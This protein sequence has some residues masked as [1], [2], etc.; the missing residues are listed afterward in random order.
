MFPFVFM[1]RTMHA[2]NLLLKIKIMRK[3]FTNLQHHGTLHGKSL[4]FEVVG[5]Q[6][7]T[8]VGV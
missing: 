6:I 4:H 8:D 5:Q 2:K 7:I 3:L 1:D